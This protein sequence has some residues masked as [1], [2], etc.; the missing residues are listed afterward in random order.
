MCSKQI[1][2]LKASDWHC[3]AVLEGPRNKSTLKTDVFG[4]PSGGFSI[5]NPWMMDLGLSENGVWYTFKHSCPFDGNIMLISR[6][7]TELYY[8]TC[9]PDIIG[10]TQLEDQLGFLSTYCTTWDDPR[11]S[12]H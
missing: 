2:P 11:S 1:V 3:F 6:I 5:F 12:Q 9:D 8:P 10:I 7:V 4:A